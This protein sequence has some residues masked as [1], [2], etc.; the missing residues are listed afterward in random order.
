MSDNT[1]W[2]IVTAGQQ[3]T[4]KIS[5]VISTVHSRSTRDLTEEMVTFTWL[6]ILTDIL[7]NMPQLPSACKEMLD[8]CRL[9]CGNDRKQL[10]KIDEFRETYKPEKA[11]HWYTRQT[12]LYP[13]LN[14]AL[15]TENIDVIFK[16]RMII[17]DLCRQLTQLFESTTYTTPTVMVYRGQ[18]M[19]LP[20]IEKLRNNIHGL[21]SMNSFV[22]TSK[23]EKRT[24]SFLRKPRQEQ[25]KTVGVLLKLTLNLDVARDMNKPFADISNFSEYKKEEEVLLTM[26]TVFRIEEVKN[27]SSDLWH[28]TATMCSF[29]DDPQVRI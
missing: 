18:R 17:I 10:E 5:T 4:P 29:L 25:D 1:S 26:G 11:L 22:S 16:F 9:A 27:Q 14:R 28:I 7:T 20:E 13:Q 23:N 2:S 8:E 19:A 24:E 12:F 15:R 6:Q 3:N 21:I